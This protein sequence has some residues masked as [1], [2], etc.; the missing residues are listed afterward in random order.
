MGAAACI[1]VLFPRFEVPDFGKKEVFAAYSWWREV[2]RAPVCGPG[3]PQASDLKQ[4]P[5]HNLPG[6]ALP[7][8]TQEQDFCQGSQLIR[9]DLLTSDEFEQKLV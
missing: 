2:S 8:L 4:S 1:D 7:C 9:R 5:H 3:L 6:C